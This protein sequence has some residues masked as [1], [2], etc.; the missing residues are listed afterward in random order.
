MTTPEIPSA[1]RALLRQLDGW[2]V[3]GPTRTS[4]PLDFGGL[5]EDGDD[6]G[7]RRRV[8]VTEVVDSVL[9]RAH[10]VDGRVLAAMWVRRPSRRGWSLD[11]AV[12]RRTYPADGYGPAR[13]TA[14][15]LKAYVGAADPAA[16]LAA[17]GLSTESEAA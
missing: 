17:C 14:T 9:I 1:A 5:S 4:G 11:S 8:T 3:A 15:Q 10:H 2:S 12:V 7:R 16:A 13:V 6:R